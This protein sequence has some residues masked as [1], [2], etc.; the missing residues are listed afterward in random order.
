MRFKFRPVTKIRR[1]IGGTLVVVFSPKYVY[2]GVLN[3]DMTV[4]G[5]SP[6]YNMDVKL[7]VND[8]MVER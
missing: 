8:Y 7:K 2:E 6:L 3:P 1:R 5:Y 4:L